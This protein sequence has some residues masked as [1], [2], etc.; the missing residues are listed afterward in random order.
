MKK[1]RSKIEKREGSGEND[2]FP[3]ATDQRPMGNGKF[4]D[5]C[6]QTIYGR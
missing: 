1:V 4:H 2:K 5:S 3:K 6:I